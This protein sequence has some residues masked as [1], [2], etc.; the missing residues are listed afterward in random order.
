[1]R[2]RGVSDSALDADRFR[3]APAAQAAHWLTALLVALI[4]V[5]GL[6]DDAALSE[7]MR[8]ARALFH[9]LAGETVFALLFLRLALQLARPT[10]V[11]RGWRAP[12]AA[13]MR[14]G[15]YALLF[16]APVTGVVALFAGGEALSVLGLGEIAS[17]WPKNRELAHY[18]GDI[19]VSLANALLAG[20]GVHAF[21]ALARHYLLGD[22]SLAAMLPQRLTK[23][24]SPP[25]D[26]GA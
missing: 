9:E 2:R 18:A 14:F 12:A 22:R 10:P 19:H 15:L 4:W 7:R 21:A 13:L 11:A 1:M 8:A 17:P 23:S 25:A 16:V 26:S 3:Y 24:K 6:A 5:L 20:A